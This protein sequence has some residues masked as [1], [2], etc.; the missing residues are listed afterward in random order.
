MQF[1]GHDQVQRSQR[2]L[3]QRRQQDARHDQQRIDFVD[4]LDG[5]GEMKSLEHVRKKLEEEH[6]GVGHDAHAHFEHDRMRIHVDELVPDEPGPA[7]IEQQSDNKEQIAEKGRQHGGAH[8]AMQAF[9]VEQIDR[10]HHAESAGSQHH[11]AQA[12]ETDP[13]SPGKLVGQVGDRAQAVEI[14][15]VGGIQAEGHDG[16]KYRLPKRELD[17][18]RALPFFFSSASAAA[19]SARR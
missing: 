5:S 6:G 12:V 19:T 1:A 4:P 7:E 8:D 9:N 10:A 3:V 18:H 2:T 17:L 16:E 11:A 13:E 14:A 15:N